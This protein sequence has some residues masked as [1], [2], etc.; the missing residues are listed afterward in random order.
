VDGDRDYK[1]Q[2]CAGTTKEWRCGDAK[3]LGRRPKGVVAGEL[4]LVKWVGCV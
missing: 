4:G 3:S 2:P 1:A